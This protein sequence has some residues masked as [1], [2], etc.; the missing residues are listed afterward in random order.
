MDTPQNALCD[1]ATAR[2]RPKWPPDT[3]DMPFVSLILP[4]V[5]ECKPDSSLPRMV[6]FLSLPPRL[7]PRRPALAAV[8]P[9]NFAEWNPN[10]GRLE[11]RR[12][13]QLQP[14]ESACI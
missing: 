5:R 3:Y 12:S 6:Q 10:V 11:A 14:V 1:A 2:K 13:L 4:A 7:L 9:H 8:Q